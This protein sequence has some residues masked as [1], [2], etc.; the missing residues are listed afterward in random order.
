MK[1][2]KHTN[3]SLKMETDSSFRFMSSHLVMILEF[4]TGILYLKISIYSTVN[5]MGL[6]CCTEEDKISGY[7]QKLNITRLA[8]QQQTSTFTSVGNEA[9]L[10]LQ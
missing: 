8:V 3:I 4:L 2:I 10:A 1:V 5:V 9:F 7:Y 6:N